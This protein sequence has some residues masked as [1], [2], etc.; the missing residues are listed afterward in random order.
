MQSKCYNTPDAV[1]QDAHPMLHNL[2]RAIADDETYTEA[3]CL[4]MDMLHPDMGKRA[5]VP[6]A[7]ASA[8]LA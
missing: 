4:L 5:T 2:R 7:M 1:G 6:Q 8:F 3:K